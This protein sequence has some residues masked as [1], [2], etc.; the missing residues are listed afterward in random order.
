MSKGEL[1]AEWPSCPIGVR[2]VFVNRHTAFCRRENDLTGKRFHDG[3]SLRKQPVHSN[4]QG[5]RATRNWDCVA[6]LFLGGPAFAFIPKRCQAPVISSFASDA[7]EPEQ[8]CQSTGKDRIDASVAD[9]AR[10][11]FSRGW[12]WIE[13]QS[14]TGNE[15]TEPIALSGEHDLADSAGLGTIGNDSPR[16][17][18]GGAGRQVNMNERDRVEGLAA[19]TWQS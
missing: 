17:P 11:P 10:W 18:R 2:F 15:P 3:K 6:I 1:T 16:W 9:R 5:E 8:S 4:L 14:R 13:I 12:C 19:E 7:G